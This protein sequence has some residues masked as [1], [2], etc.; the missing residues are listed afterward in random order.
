MHAFMLIGP[1]SERSLEVSGLRKIL[2]LIPGC[3][4]WLAHMPIPL[5]SYWQGEYVSCLLSLLRQMTDI[6][7][8]HLMENFQSKEELKVQETH[9]TSWQNHPQVHT[10]VLC[11]VELWE[12]SGVSLEGKHL[13]GQKQTGDSS[14]DHQKKSDVIIQTPEQRSLQLA[15]GRCCC[16]F[17]KMKW[18]LETWNKTDQLFPLRLK[19]RKIDFCAD[20]KGHE[21]APLPQLV[22]PNKL[23]LH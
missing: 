13:S 11:S 23:F 10:K 19:R 4:S 21:R 1:H 15:L 8:Q 22:P 3:F 5:V 17:N 2:L 6:H 14:N 16:C 18:K 20:F 12:I 7:F 9:E